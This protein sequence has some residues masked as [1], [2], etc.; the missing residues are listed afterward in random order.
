MRLPRSRL[1]LG[2]IAMLA[3][4]LIPLT[5]RSLG[6]T[7]EARNRTSAATGAD[8]T[9]SFAEAPVEIP[10]AMVAEDARDLEGRVARAGDDWSAVLTYTS[11]LERDELEAMVDAAAQNADFRRRRATFD[12]QRKVILYDGADGSVMTVTLNADGDAVTLGAVRISP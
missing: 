12:A 7:D 2:G 4:A 11:E 6:G 1:L 5:I 9:R 10:A 8:G 3:I